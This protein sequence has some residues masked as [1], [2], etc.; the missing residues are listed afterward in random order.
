[1]HLTGVVDDSYGLEKTDRGVMLTFDDAF[2]SGNTPEEDTVRAADRRFNEDILKMEIYT[3]NGYRYIPIDADGYERWPIPG[4]V[5]LSP[6]DRSPEI[7]LSD[8]CRMVSHA[9]STAGGYRSVMATHGLSHGTAFFE[10]MLLSPNVRLGI[11]TLEAHLGGP[12]GMDPFGYAVTDTGHKYHDAVKTAINNVDFQF[13][14]CPIL[15][16]L[17]CLPETDTARR[18]RPYVDYIPFEHEKRHFLQCKIRSTTN[19]RQIVQGSYLRLFVNGRDCG[20]IFEGLYEGCYFP[21]FSV[22][23]EGR[24][25]ANFGPHFVN[26]PGDVAFMGWNQLAL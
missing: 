1:M 18:R 2:S 6:Y 7:R 15:G 19:T 21:M 22:Y 13:G 3:K 10:A 11:G 20:K 8:R 24:A 25:M 23:R 17:V 26:P 9:D 14:E 16:I 5:S 4:T 12:V